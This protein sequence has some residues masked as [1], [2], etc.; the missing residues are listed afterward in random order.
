MAGNGPAAG[1]TKKKK[2]K[3]IMVTLMI[4]LSVVVMSV[5][6]AFNTNRKLR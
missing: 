4:V 3:K 6:L 2:G 5:A 1:L